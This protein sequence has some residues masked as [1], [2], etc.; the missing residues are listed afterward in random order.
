MYLASLQKSRSKDQLCSKVKKCRYNVALNCRRKNIELT[1]KEGFEIEG[2]REEEEA[3]FNDLF[4]LLNIV[5]R[6]LP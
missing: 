5:L 2:L 6:F 4:G 1:R 3:P